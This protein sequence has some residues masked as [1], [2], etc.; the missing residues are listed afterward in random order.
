MTV[1]L[2]LLTW[3]ELKGCQHDVPKIKRDAF[4]QIYCVDGGSIDGTIEYLE[5][6]GIPVYLQTAKGL[7]QAHKDAINHCTCDTVIFFHPK[8]SVPVSD[9]LRFRRYFE[10]G[11]NLVVAS[12][13]MKQSVNEEDSHILKPRKWFVLI[14]ALCAKLL[15]QREGNTIWDVLHGFRGVN[16]HAFRL[17]QLSDNNPSVDIETVCR[18]Y[19][20]HL[21]RIEFPTKERQRLS[22]KT[23]F[24]AFATGKKLIRY[25]IWEARRHD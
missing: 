10:Q 1:A 24:K 6:E 13:M 21:K 7:N 22:G 5:A 17:I 4:D 15:F 18:Y 25:M 16:I 23:H 2:C 11:Y 8:G 20:L 19:K 14:L 3:N 12:R 9:T